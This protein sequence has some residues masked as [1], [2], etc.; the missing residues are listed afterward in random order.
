M[1]VSNNSPEETAEFTNF[2]HIFR[3]S[4]KEKFFWL[5]SLKNRRRFLRFFCLLGGTIFLLVGFVD[6]LSLG[7]SNDF[8]LLFGVRVTTV[9]VAYI[10]AYAM[11]EKRSEKT[12]NLFI[13]TALGTLVFTLIVVPFFRP[14]SQTEHQLISVFMVMIF[15][16]FLPISPKL[17]L[18]FSLF[19]STGTLTASILFLAQNF[20]DSFGLLMLSIL[21]HSVGFVWLRTSNKLNRSNV[22]KNKLLT[23]EVARREY[24]ENQL[25]YRLHELQ[26]S[27]QRLEEQGMSLVEIADSA[28]IAH[29]ESQ[30][31]RERMRDAIDNINEGFVL[32]DKDLKLIICNQ[33]YRDL[34]GYSKDDAARGVSVDKLAEIDA[35]ENR[36]KKGSEAHLQLIKKM[37]ISKNAEGEIIANLTDGRWIQIR[38]KKTPTGNI[39]S[40][41]A[42][43][44]KIKDAEER[45]RYYA[46]HDALTG[47]PSLRHGKDMLQQAIKTAGEHQYQLAVLFVDLDGFKG[48]NDTH[49]HD[50]GDLVLKTVASRIEVCLGDKGFAARIGGDEF[51]V[52]LNLKDPRIDKLSIS[53]QLIKKIGDPISW[54]GIELSVGASIGISIFPLHGRDAEALLKSADA[55]MYKAKNNGKNQ[56]ILA[57]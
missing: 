46:N 1:T 18:I 47:L 2:L 53:G 8:F 55:A 36:L 28:T 6:F 19:L 17:I 30:T 23:D 16:G 11:T 20:G 24:T 37:A 26:D 50:A 15:Y 54:H 33:K 40:L 13:C 4:E 38:D 39:V 34:Y 51:I 43:I 21:G 9:G 10:T 22:W 49:G 56:V 25:E 7:L 52:V 31:S 29:S 45:V 3:D 5:N 14:N 12:A 48:I 32:F 42:D 27:Q 57:T 35:K 41:Q 44:T